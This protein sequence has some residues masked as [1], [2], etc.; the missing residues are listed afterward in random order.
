M[1]IQTA[2][3]DKLKKN[4]SHHA[5]IPVWM[6]DCA[7]WENNDILIKKFEHNNK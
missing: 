4:S 1:R 2:L 3:S 6:H 7:K 5:S